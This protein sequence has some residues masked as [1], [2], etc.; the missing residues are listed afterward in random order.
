M[1]AVGVESGVQ[2]D[3]FAATDHE[4]KPLFARFGP[5]V[6]SARVWGKRG[7]VGK[8]DHRLPSFDLGQQ[9]G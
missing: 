5:H 4:Q 6:G 7:S 2:I 9:R 8:V 1:G 3:P